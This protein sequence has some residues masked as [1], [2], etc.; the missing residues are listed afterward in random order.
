MNKILQMIWENGYQQFG[1]T[2]DSNIRDQNPKTNTSKK[3]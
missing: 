3:Q 1:Y 2:F